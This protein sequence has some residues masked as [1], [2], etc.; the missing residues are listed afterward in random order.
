MATEV[1]P[2]LFDDMTAFRRQRDKEAFQRVLSGVGAAAGSYKGG[3]QGSIAMANRLRPRQMSAADFA[4]KKNAMKLEVLQAMSNAETDRIRAVGSLS[5]GSGKSVES[6]ILKAVLK[7]YGVD[8]GTAEGM[9]AGY[10]AGV[11][12]IETNF[13]DNVAAAMGGNVSAGGLARAMQDIQAAGLTTTADPEVILAELFRELSMQETME[14]SGQGG[15]ETGIAFLE[16]VRS[17]LDILGR[18]GMDL[19]SI[20]ARFKDDT[21]AQYIQEWAKDAKAWPDLQAKVAAAKIGA[22]QA[23]RDQALAGLMAQSGAG[24]PG[25]PVSDK[26]TEAIQAYKQ[27]L[28][29]TGLGVSPNVSADAVDM[30]ID[31]A[32]PTQAKQSEDH[33]QY[34]SLLEK[35]DTMQQDPTAQAMRQKIYENPEF[36][37]FKT[38]R[39]L[40]TNEMAFKAF[41]REHADAYHRMKQAD[42]ATLAAGA[43]AGT[44]TSVVRGGAEPAQVKTG[45][46]AEAPKPG[47][48]EESVAPRP[49]AEPTATLTERSPAPTADTLPPGEARSDRFK[50]P[51]S[52]QPADDLSAFDGAEIFV[53]D[54]NDVWMLSADR[55][56]FSLATDEDIQQLVDED[57]YDLVQGVERLDEVKALQVGQPAPAPEQPVAEPAAGEA[58]PAVPD[59]KPSPITPRSNPNRESNLDRQLPGIGRAVNDVGAVLARPGLAIQQAWGRA[60]NGDEP[61]NSNKEKV[62]VENTGIDRKPPLNV[63]G[64]EWQVTKEPPMQWP[65]E[66]ELKKRKEALIRAKLFGNAE[67]AT[68]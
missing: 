45:A 26:M 11:A 38:E 6:D 10:N 13:A 44:P 67:G 12:S 28:A 35:L 33:E 37:R 15:R 31:R 46:E 43:Q 62:D 23:V 54:G 19:D 68:P 2:S 57:L 39:N 48:P 14:K 24:T 42:R 30:A 41:R 9:A 34:L 59:P 60:A 4:Q 63:Q 16:M 17:M 40:Q 1:S 29:E 18:E 55:T 36:Q 5:R 27:I 21:R 58:P 65:T 49:T 56:K 61:P 47:T 32:V 53:S 20:L 25:A 51:A 22:Q 50:P 3:V 8:A 64:P 7:M 66:A 52:S